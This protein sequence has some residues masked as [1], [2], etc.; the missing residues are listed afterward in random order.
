ME[1]LTYNGSLLR[2]CDAD[3]I[4]VYEV[5]YDAGSAIARHAHPHAGFSVLLRGSLSE[6]Y[7]RRSLDWSEGTVGF[8]PADEEH[9]NRT[10]EGAHVLIVELA[11]EWLERA[12]AESL[13]PER[14]VVAGAGPLPWLGVRLLAEARLGDRA[15]RLAV[16]GIALEMLAAL[17]REGERD[18]GEPPWLRRAGD[19]LRASFAESLSLAEVARRVD[20]PPVRL[21]RAFRRAHGCSVGEYIRRLRVEE[22][23]RLLAG[24]D[25]PI[26]EVAASSGFC[27]Q[28]HLSRVF[29]RAT[30]LTPMVYRALVRP[31]P[32]RPKR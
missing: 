9:S 6:V 1:S 7:G 31:A 8:H 24:G 21:A 25:T 17:A 3:G 23:R 30:G 12:R 14:S 28:A 13:R 4:G 19:L 16:Q 10:R 11:A 18:A 5:R 15:S 26:S 32:N 27:D 22:A 29:K 2:A 20:A